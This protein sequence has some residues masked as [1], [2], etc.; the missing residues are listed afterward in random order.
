MA[1]LILKGRERTVRMQKD[2][3][4]QVSKN[5]ERGMHGNQKRQKERMKDFRQISKEG[6]LKA[7]NTYLQ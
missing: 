2:I 6:G 3:I 1:N 7:T 5:A 4:N